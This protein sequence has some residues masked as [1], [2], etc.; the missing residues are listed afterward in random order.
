MPKAKKNK[1]PY[2]FSWRVPM[3]ALV[4]VLVL[5]VGG[6]TTAAKMEENDAFCA[7]CHTEPESTYFDRSQAAAA[8]DLASAHHAE[9]TRCIDCHSGAGVTGRISGMQVGFADLVAYKLGTAKQPAPLTVPI[10]DENCLKCHQD[11]P[12]TQNFQRHFH[13]F[14]SQW[15]KIDKNAGTCVSCHTGHKTD[16]TADQKFMATDTVQPVCIACHT[17]AGEG[18]RQ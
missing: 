15:Q 14:L 16:G 7:S 5:A 11:V 17:A 13:Y 3:F 18:P 9:G 4:G 1:S 8:V 10:S 12:Q 2:K 6:F